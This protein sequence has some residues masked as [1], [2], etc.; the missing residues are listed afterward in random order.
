MALLLYLATAA[1]LLW[2]AQRY[3]APIERR[4]MAVLLLLPL[5]FCGKALLTGG[6]YAP[7]D[8]PYVTEPLKAM[9]EPLGLAPIHN[10]AMSDLYAP[11][12]PWREAGEVALSN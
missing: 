2:L 8:G 4:A 11:M 3:I 6:V 5:V 9:M 7:A 10:R 12:I 1:V